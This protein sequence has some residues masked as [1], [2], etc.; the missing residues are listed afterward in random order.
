MSTSSG[1]AVLA[2]FLSLF[3]STILFA[4]TER[5]SIRGTVL[6]STG[7]VVPD[8][9]VTAVNVGTGVRNTATT[10]DAGN[11]Q[12]P[13]LPP[14]TYNVEVEKTS[15]KKLV[16]ENV[17]VEVATVTGLDLTLEV[18]AVT[19]SV[20]VTG[21]APQ[22]RTES[23]EV[24]TSVNAKSYVDLPLPAGGRSPEQFIF[25]AP[26]TSGN[27]FDAHING[28]QTLSKEIQ[29]DG[30]TM[31]IA[32]VGGDP[33]VLNSFVPEAVQEFSIATSTY[34]AEYGNSGGGVERFTV[35]SGTNELHGTLYEFLRNDKLDAR[36]FFAARRSVH[37]E[38]QYGGTVGGPIYIP[39]VYDGRNKSFFF[40]NYDGFKYRSGAASLVGSVPTAAFRAGD[41]STLLNPDGSLLQLYDYYSTAPDGQGGYTRLPFSNNQIPSNL[42]SEVS[43][44]IMSYV[45]LPN[46][47]GS[48]FQNYRASAGSWN[49]NWAITGKLDQVI[50]SSHRLSGMWNWGDFSDSGPVSILPYPV[51]ISRDGY[52][53]NRIYRLSE[54]WVISP[55]LINHFAFGVTRQLQLLGGPEFGEPWAERVGLTG[56]ASHGQFPVVFIDPFTA[57]GQ[58]QELLM[59]NST[60]FAW[61]DSL[62]WV[63]GKHNLKFGFEFRKYRQNQAVPTGTGYYT[64]SRYE[65]AFPTAALRNSTGL[66]FASFLLGEVDSGSLSVFDY[67]RGMRYPY[68]AWYA[69]DD[70]KVTPRLTLNLGLRYDL[71]WPMAEINDNYS[72]MD[73]SVPNPRANGLPGAIIF[74]GEGEGRAGRHRLY[75]QIAYTNFGPR[76]GFAW[77]ANEKTVVRSAIGISYYATGVHG[78][79]NAKPPGMG[80]TANPVFNS[81]DLGLTSGFNWAGGFP[82]NWDRPPFIDPGFGFNQSVTMW[83]E[84][85]K[86][87][88]TRIDWNF[89]IQRQIV[90]NLLFDIAYVGSKS[91]HL[92][93]GVHNRNQVDSK[94]LPL[95]GLL[96]KRID[97][98][99]VVAAGYSAPFPGFSGTLAQALRPFP[100]Y[101]GVG[102]NNS[103]NMGNMSYNSLQIKVEKQ[104]SHGLF[105]LSSYTWSKTLTDASSAL[106]GFFSTSA[107]DQYNRRLEKAL[108]VFDTP[109][110]LVTAFNYELPIGPGK[111]FANVTGVAGKLLGGWSINGYLEYQSGTPIGVGI[112]NQLPLFNS[113]NLPDVVSGVNPMASWGDNF[114]PRRDLYLNINAFKEPAPWTFGNAP[115]V[116]NVR[117]FPGLNENLGIIKRTT[118]KEQMNVEFRFEMFNA[119][120]RVRFGGPSSNVSD[121]INFGKISG[122]ANGARVGQFALKFNY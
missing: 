121:P 92:T 83:N 107:R 68:L 81:Q 74:A 31:T 23:S 109:S 73:P 76:V 16:R 43:K 24:A 1:K 111:P 64:F 39:K 57:W 96:T 3:L 77:S 50:S 95:Q 38:N 75:D 54:D 101:Q 80:F 37:R 79:G 103:N 84:N 33:R 8:A 112:N 7:A 34:S 70:F 26:G 48:N 11:Y 25:L 29:V 61:S 2:V 40:F 98:P 100:Q 21:A 56:V 5:G 120:N 36:G 10:T 22:L 44:K 110:R 97:D 105:V 93:T 53:G 106:S 62:T 88:S 52:S 108:S 20:T 69:Q 19:E 104:F 87:P 12:I 102:Q 59:T 6:D 58:N 116:M 78:G 115:S 51:R 90:P 55:T 71:F 28:S 30:I 117:V 42:I 65:T 4:Q 41:L 82:T 99:A 35:K 49:N 15:F 47:P 86:A 13:F 118:I 32:E 27:T 9:T 60:T 91:T 72:I 45:P 85:A 46:V 63:K 114:D 113:R 66:A 94:Y 119:F 122:Q 14:G 18:G 89:G 67:T 17:R